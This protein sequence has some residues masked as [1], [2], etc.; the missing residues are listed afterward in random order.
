MAAEACPGAAVG[1][2]VGPV[3]HLSIAWPS[4]SAVRAAVRK[5]FL[6]LSVDQCQVRA[7]TLSTGRTSARGKALTRLLVASRMR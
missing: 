6:D 3:K 2:V 7:C 5:G 4:A 1:C